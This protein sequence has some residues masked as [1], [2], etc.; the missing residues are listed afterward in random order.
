MQISGDLNLKKFVVAFTAAALLAVSALVTWG[1]Q[2]KVN[3]EGTW[4]L[5][6]ATTEDTDP[7]LEAYPEERVTELANGGQHIYLTLG[8]NDTAVFYELGYITNGTWS[9][10]GAGATIEFEG[11]DILNPATGEVLLPKSANLTLNASAQG[12]PEL[13]M[14]RGKT[15][16][17]FGQGE[18]K[19][20]YANGEDGAQDTTQFAEAIAEPQEF[21]NEI[22]VA[23]DSK[24]KMTINASG[25][26]EFG[27]LAYSLSVKNKGTQPISLWIPDPVKV[28]NKEVPVLITATLEP[29]QVMATPL[30]LDQE[31]LGSASPEAAKG[32]TG[33]I[34]IDDAS[35]N[36]IG[37]YKFTL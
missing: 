36:E 5:K 32:A 18:A 16:W 23:D 7:N 35:G 30:V 14:T 33:V 1:C 12:G 13:S 19:T 31:K 3:F 28:G 27:D 26:T 25:T 9:K 21:A 15:T 4:D 22:V 29:G 34:R 6:Y 37:S 10:A 2:P 24:V 11:Q 8:A 20:P 17:V